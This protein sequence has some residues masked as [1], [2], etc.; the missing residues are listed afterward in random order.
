MSAISLQA[1]VLQLG[2]PNLGKVSVCSVTWEAT[3]Q[4]EAYIFEDL[5]LSWHI[6]FWIEFLRTCWIGDGWCCCCAFELGKILVCNCLVR[7]SQSSWEE[8][9]KC[10]CI[11]A[12]Y[13][14]CFIGG[15]QMQMSSC[16]IV[17]VQR[18]NYS[19]VM[20]YISC[21]QRKITIV[22]MTLLKQV[23]MASCR[24]KESLYIFVLF[25]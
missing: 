14:C 16:S 13:E 24:C 17:E 6:G 25:F 23:R 18:I 9:A 10:V 22:T 1:A 11:V 8:C 20:L 4:F 19:P 7:I 12:V 21:S 2:I 5:A 3:L 15:K